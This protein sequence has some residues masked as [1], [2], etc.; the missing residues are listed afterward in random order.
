MYQDLM[1]LVELSNTYNP[2]HLVFLCEIRF[3]SLFQYWPEKI[4][5]TTLQKIKELSLHHPIKELI[6]ITGIPR[7]LYGITHTYFLQ[8]IV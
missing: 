6:K 2:E 8:S 3:L 7:E 4:K 1:T 5:D